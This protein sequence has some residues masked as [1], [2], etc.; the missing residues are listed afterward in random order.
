MI[1][2][3]E[4]EMKQL[5]APQLVMYT[6]EPG[7]NREVTTIIMSFFLLLLLIIIIAL[8][9]LLIIIAI[10]CRCGCGRSFGGVA[11]ENC[12]W[13]SIIII[14]KLITFIIFNKNHIIIIINMCL[15]PDEY[16]SIY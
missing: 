11:G 16:P 13:Q 2:V 5:G 6:K 3:A 15:Q 7:A 8:L 1:K 14:I 9:H 10:I 12:R 4:A